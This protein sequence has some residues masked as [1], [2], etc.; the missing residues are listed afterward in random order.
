[1][2]SMPWPRSG[3]VRAHE[4]R[5]TSTAFE[6][7]TYRSHRSDDAVWPPV[8]R[9]YGGSEQADKRRRTAALGLAVARLFLACESRT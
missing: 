6:A 9:A 7:E 5:N 2:D 4:Y 3:F 8:A 1:M